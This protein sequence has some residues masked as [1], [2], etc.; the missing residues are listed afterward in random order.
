R[1]QLSA[2]DARFRWHGGPSHAHQL[3]FSMAANSRSILSAS[4]KSAGCSLVNP[5]TART[6][7]KIL[8]FSAADPCRSR[9]NARAMLCRSGSSCYHGSDQRQ[10]DQDDSQRR[11]VPY[12]GA[13]QK[14]P[15]CVHGEI[16]DATPKIDLNTPLGHPTVLARNMR[17][18][19]ACCKQGKR[20][21]E[22]L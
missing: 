15:R 8:S 3:P 14:N 4:S 16:G 22:I 11:H 6:F 12:E 7:S 10:K 2:P 9:I 5:P 18:Q 20:L 21:D 13:Q 17:Y 1:C 19:N